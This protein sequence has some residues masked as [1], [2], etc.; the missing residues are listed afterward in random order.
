MTGRA[1]V[2]NTLNGRLDRIYAAI[3]ATRTDDLS[4]VVPT[5][6]AGGGF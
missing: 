4:K 2:P 5:F 6:S 1:R 3:G